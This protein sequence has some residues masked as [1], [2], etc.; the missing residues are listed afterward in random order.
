MPWQPE[1][2]WMHEAKCCLPVKGSNRP[3]LQCTGVASAWVL[4]YS[5]R[6]PRTTCRSLWNG[7]CTRSSSGGGQ[8]KIFYPRMMGMEQPSQGSGHGFMLTEFKKCL[9]NILTHMV[10]FWAVL[11]GIRIWTQWFLWVPLN[12]DILQFYFS[13]FLPSLAVIPS[14]HQLSHTVFITRQTAV[15]EGAIKLV[16]SV[17]FDYYQS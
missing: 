16:L 15:L 7:S 3:T 9:D 4:L 10:C 12:L 11:C 14:V 17:R 13:I 2:P 1:G 8:E 5:F 6:N